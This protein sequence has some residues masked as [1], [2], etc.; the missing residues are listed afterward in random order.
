MYDG[1]PLVGGGLLPPEV[2]QVPL[3]RAGGVLVG[4]LDTVPAKPL[5][6]EGASPADT[7][8]RVDH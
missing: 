3:Q 6:A 2:V 5:N 1:T 7:L 8:L 4:R